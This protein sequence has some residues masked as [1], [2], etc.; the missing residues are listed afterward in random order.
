MPKRRTNRR[1]KQLRPDSPLHRSAVGVPSPDES[2]RSNQQNEDDEEQNTN[3]NEKS[4]GFGPQCNVG[5]DI[6]NGC[7]VIPYNISI[8]EW[9]S[10]KVYL[11]QVDFNFNGQ[12]FPSSIYE[13]ATII[14]KL[15]KQSTAL[16]PILCN[17]EFNNIFMIEF[18]AYVC[19]SA[20]TN[21][22]KIQAN[23]LL[24]HISE[25]GKNPF[26]NSLIFKISQTPN[27]YKYKNVSR[28]E[29]LKF[30]ST[31][32]E[33]KSKNCL[34]NDLLI[35]DRY[36]LYDPGCIEGMQLFGS[37]DNEIEQTEKWG[38]N[39]KLMAE[40]YKVHKCF[41]VRS[42]SKQSCPFYHSLADA[43]RPL[44]QFNYSSKKCSHLAEDCYNGVNCQS[45]HNE[46]EH[47]Y[48]PEF[49][50]HSECMYWKQNGNCKGPLC[51][52][53][54]PGQMDPPIGK[55]KVPQIALPSSLI[56]LKPS[57]FSLTR[58]TAEIQIPYNSNNISNNNNSNNI[59]NNNNHFN[60]V[61]NHFLSS[62][63][64]QSLSKSFNP[65]GKNKNCFSREGIIFSLRQS[66]DSTD[67]LLTPIQQ[68]QIEDKKEK[69]P[70]NNNNN[71]NNNLQLPPGVSIS[72]NLL[73]QQQQQQQQYNINTTSPNQKTNKLSIRDST[74][75]CPYMFPDSDLKKTYENDKELSDEQP[76]SVAFQYQLKC[77]EI[78]IHYTIQVLKDFFGEDKWISHVNEYFLNSSSPESNM[79]MEPSVWNI[80]IIRDIVKN[81]KFNNKLIFDT[82]TTKTDAIY[83]FFCS[84]IPNND[85]DQFHLW[86]YLIQI[87]KMES[88]YHNYNYVYSLACQFEEFIED[89]GNSEFKIELEHSLEYW[90]LFSKYLWSRSSVEKTFHILLIAG[91]LPQFD[92]TA[93]AMYL[94]HANW[95]CI[96]DFDNNDNHSIFRETCL[97]SS[98]H[99]KPI[100][101]GSL[102]DFTSSSFNV[103]DLI[104]WFS[105]RINKTKQQ[106]ILPEEYS[107]KIIGGKQD[108][109]LSNYF[110]KLEYKNIHV[111]IL[112]YDNEILSN[113]MLSSHINHVLNY[114]YR[115]PNFNNI[116]FT[117]FT[118]HA[119]QLKSIFLEP[120]LSRSIESV[121]FPK[122]CNGFQTVIHS[123][124]LPILIP[125][126]NENSISIS[127][128]YHQ[129]CPYFQL[130][131]LNV[132]KFTVESKKQAKLNWVK[133]GSV[134]WRLLCDDEHSF[135]LPTINESFKHC[136]SKLL[137]LCD[138]AKQLNQL[139]ELQITTNHKFEANTLGRLLLWNIHT[140]Y[141]SLIN[142][143]TEELSQS[144]IQIAKEILNEISKKTNKNVIILMLDPMIC[145]TEKVSLLLKDLKI[146]LVLL[147]INIEFNSNNNS[148]SLSSSSDCF[149]FIDEISVS[150]V[151]GKNECLLIK[152]YLS[153]VIKENDPDYKFTLAKI[154]H[155]IQILEENYSFQPTL[156][157]YTILYRLQKA[158]HVEEYIFN[159]LSSIQFDNI[160][161]L[162][163]LSI[164]FTYRF[165][166]EPIPIENLLFDNFTMENLIQF[167][168][169][170]NLKEFL[171]FDKNFQSIIVLNISIANDI[172]RWVCIHLNY[173][174]SDITRLF[175]DHIVPS[176]SSSSY[177]IS[178]SSTSP[179]SYSP[180]LNIIL[181]IFYRIEHEDKFPELIS[182]ISH[183]YTFTLYVFNKLESILNST[184][185]A[186][187]FA[188]FLWTF[189]EQN[190]ET[191]QRINYLMET[192][193]DRCTNAYESY[194]YFLLHGMMFNSM[195]DYHIAC[196]HAGN[197]TQILPLVNTLHKRAC[198]NFYKARGK[199]F[200]KLDYTSDYLMFPCMLELTI[201]TKF[202]N[203]YL[204][205]IL[206]ENSLLKSQTMGTNGINSSSS[207][208]L[209]HITNPQQ[210]KN[211]NDHDGNTSANNL[212]NL[213]NFQ[214]I[215]YFLI[216]N[217]IPS[218]L[219]DSRSICIELFH[220]LD[221]FSSFS[222]DKDLLI[223]Y[224]LKREWSL[225]RSSLDRIDLIKK[226]LSPFLGENQAHVISLVPLCSN[227]NN[228]AY[229][230]RRMCLWNIIE[231]HKKNKL[232][233]WFN[234]TQFI[235]DSID[236][237]IHNVQPNDENSAFRDFDLTSWISLSCIKN[238][239]IED[240]LSLLTSWCLNTTKC[241]N[242]HA[243]IANYYRFVVLFIDFLRDP[244]P[245]KSEVCNQNLK[246][247]TDLCASNDYPS[248][249]IDYCFLFLS[250]STDLQ[251]LCSYP[252]L[253]KF[254]KNDLIQFPGK[255]IFNTP[256]T[257]D[258]DHCDN[259]QKYILFH[260][261]QIPIKNLDEIPSSIS[262]S[263]DGSA[264]ILFSIAFSWSNAKAFNITPK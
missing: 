128:I 131:F 188:R 108:E 225:I 122:V 252:Q 83:D 34:Q 216:S 14:T 140:K 120:V 60:Q 56:G 155:Q 71:N 126:E 215:N 69:K 121:S 59:A 260:D 133:G 211:N 117:T 19:L 219:E 194:Y 84:P 168:S 146:P 68:Q 152:S 200:G 161:L 27:G 20:I 70:T 156:F 228:F 175:I 196:S 80:T 5:D 98:K 26:G 9:T 64:P 149:N 190:D 257:S 223:R 40:H 232:I 226:S 46:F 75:K 198:S 150:N 217:D 18:G 123:D 10:G 136:Y 241:T 33:I 174:I 132:E 65:S 212:N 72:S 248:E 238:C 1:G 178:S 89:Q 130:L 181:K 90:L 109:I 138:K 167:I 54:H 112:S 42:H 205:S 162:V 81:M 165:A 74:L 147:N 255:L 114:I 37:T 189:G 143:F 24:N 38:F 179:S 201:R 262:P 25:P 154:N 16:Q 191:T 17:G 209:N 137:S 221:L 214:L 184:Y 207:L 187:G 107:H 58:T 224:R 41:R 113:P 250:K 195:F 239:K 32:L 210:F 3:S 233:T 43:R 116:N 153:Q 125:D 44:S 67:N 21:S 129:L 246:T 218:S 193:V 92:H 2:N 29:T 45:S 76:I 57:N 264:D 220:K 55:K 118:N 145:N 142:L 247:C 169:N 163:L 213:P 159:H 245:K 243:I 48:H 53:Y 79:S 208:L 151:L 82:P 249:I 139:V 177:L 172:I 197:W 6:P 186:C 192:A 251:D 12:V 47:F 85:E 203:Y 135:P 115:L 227:D 110:S 235:N 51:S 4:Y 99:D 61:N 157:N 263:E 95:D 106:Q 202:L 222:N 124:Q 253:S 148:S 183:D 35:R 111:T 52:F 141:P 36:W 158:F 66:K 7:T 182:S 254:K 77:Q 166:E 259:Q 236:Y 28:S 176:S 256:S 73:D 160:E 8:E 185:S 63:S 144:D 13:R 171:F 87:I 23:Q 230:A 49:L 86:C 180:L 104:T 258:V 240:V 88:I 94:C 237:T 119:K 164:A 91:S 22:F 30:L 62:Q 93:G 101:Y 100:Y 170:L 244:T 97:I 229:E 134:S 39:T 234:P 105:M 231:E 242:N 15:C 103:N 11:P 206:S 261:Y 96:I 50:R 173:S 78:L 199:L 31:K 204:Y 102:N 127:S